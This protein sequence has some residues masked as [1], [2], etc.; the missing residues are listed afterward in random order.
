MKYTVIHNGPAHTRLKG[1]TLIE[2]L[3]VIAIISILASILFPVFARARENA[4]RSSCQS[5]LKQIGLGIMQ[6]TQDYDEQFPMGAYTNWTGAWPATTQPYIKSVQVFRCPTGSG[7]EKFDPT[8]LRGV[9]ID[10]AANGMI[11]TELRDGVWR[12]TIV[13][14]IG[15]A[16]ATL[17]NSTHQNTSSKH[18]SSIARPSETILVAELHAGKLSALPP[19]SGSALMSPMSARGNMAIIDGR[20]NGWAANYHSRIPAGNRSGSWPDGPDGVVTAQHLETANFLFCDG[21]VKAMRPTA[22]NPRGDN[23]S[24]TNMWNGWR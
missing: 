23:Y 18:V 1:F 24:T 6:Y 8:D 10:Y 21:R 2:L 9:P 14:P 22:T 12:N 15:L 20:T 13:G 11:N 5:N 3:V 16:D 17:M 4:R 19:R 7:Y